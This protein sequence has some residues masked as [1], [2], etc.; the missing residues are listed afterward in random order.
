MYHVSISHHNITNYATMT[1]NIKPYSVILN[2]I[3]GK[4]TFIVALQ[5]SRVYAGQQP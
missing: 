5:A 1:T 2:T 4:R 3:S